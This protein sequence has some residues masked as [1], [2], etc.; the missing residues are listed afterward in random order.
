MSFDP[1]SL[2]RQD[3]RTVVVT[4]ANTGLGFHNA[5]DLAALGAHVVLACRTESRATAAMEQ[6]AADVPGAELE[7]VELDLAS[8]DSVRAAAATVRDRHD[9]L[10]VLINNAGVMWTDE[11]HTA[12]GFELQ[13]AANYWG[14]FLWTMSLIDLLPDATASRVVPLAS[15]AHAAPPRTIRFDDIHWETGY[16]K[17]QA[18]AQTKLACLMFA[19]E[20][21]RRLDAAGKQIRSV[22]A[23]PGVS[24]TELTRT[25]N[26]LITTV[27]KFTVAP[28]FTHPPRAA[29]QSTLVAALD[30]SIEGGAYVGPQGFREMKGDPG[31]AEI[32]DGALD[33][34][35]Q[36]RLWD[37]SVELTGADL[38]F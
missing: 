18:Y 6:I 7:F 30:P 12:D 19:L 15:I 4:G 2:P 22:A 32:N 17:Q 26:P 16:D 10:D 25:L 13:M 5:R 34:D 9:S 27:L 23:H 11:E 14:H 33:T 3:G 20:L 24:P 21:D 36:A 31:P 29:S 35:A 37:L 28:F 8:L 38:P 1:M